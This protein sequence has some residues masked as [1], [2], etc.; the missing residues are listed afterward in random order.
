MGIKTNLFNVLVGLSGFIAIHLTGMFEFIAFELLGILAWGILANIL[1]STGI[2]IELL[3]EYYF[4]GT[5][6]LQHLRWLFFILGT[7]LYCYVT[8]SYAVFY[9]SPFIDFLI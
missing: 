5:L 8:F 2:L 7:L 1:F 6:K 4:N 9:Y 3:N